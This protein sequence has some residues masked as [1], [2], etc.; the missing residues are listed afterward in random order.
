MHIID[1]DYD[2]PEHFIAQTPLEKRDHSK[3]LT[4]NR[5]VGKTEIKQFFNILDFKKAMLLW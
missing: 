2:L 4:Y 3:L 1:F 5:A